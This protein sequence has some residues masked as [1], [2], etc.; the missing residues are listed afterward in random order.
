MCP[1]LFD[2]PP[3]VRLVAD[4]NH[5]HVL[6]DWTWYA[7][8]CVRTN[9]RKRMMAM[10]N[11]TAQPQESGER[12]IAS[13]FE[14]VSGCVR[15]VGSMNVD[16]TVTTKDLPKPGETVTGG[17]MRML[18]G[19]KSGNQAAVSALLGADVKIVGC[20][21][22][23]A[24]GD[25]LVEQ[26][27]KVGVGTEGIHRVGDSSGTALIMVD[28]A[29]E[30]SIVY[31]PGSNAAVTPELI[32]ASAETLTSGSV[33]GLCLES[34][35]ESVVEAARLCHDAGMTVLL[36]D[37]PFVADLPQDLV[38]AC[39]VL[40]VNEHELAQ[41]IGIDEGAVT[42]WH[43][44]DWNDIAL[45]L[46][47]HGFGSAVVTLG[48]EGSV[49]LDGTEAAMVDA[50]HVPVVDTTGCGDA[51]MGAILVGLASGF[52]LLD[53]A[54]MGSYV[55]AYAAMHA[56]AQSSYGTREQIMEALL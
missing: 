31:S 38:D 20:V 37:S 10:S 14:A 28:F 8:A 56:G 50:V 2:Y 32:R 21:G 54:R 55:A 40:L 23:D 33:L 45:R 51:F 19:G 36:N 7:I 24:N 4:N 39:D 43:A 26:L 29:G 12:D 9:R 41:L 15:I 49:V 6:I 1:G 22:S 47:T 53:A 30:N 18:P 35:M 5:S 52:S 46:V 42:D 17:P 25:Y 27:S 48:S 11:N 13:L 34:P 16:Y 3:L 44:A